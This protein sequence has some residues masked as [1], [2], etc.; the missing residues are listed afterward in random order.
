M[1]IWI[2][3]D[4]HFNHFNI[5]KYCNRPY[6]TIKEMNDALIKNWNDC[7]DDNDI[8][9][10]LG[11]FCFARPSEAFEVTKRL[12]SALKGY[13]VIVKGN[14]DFKKLKYTDIGWKFETFQELGIGRF[15]FRHRPDGP[16][17]LQS[18]AKMYDFVFYG[19]VHDKTLDW[20]PI[21][22][23]NVCLDANNFKPMDITDYFTDGEIGTIKRLVDYR[24]D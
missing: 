13:K 12:T 5:I 9:F 24:G 4:T 23:I 20:A 1:K 14:H 8:V 11:D 6:A 2:C 3:S 18:A 19:H 15:C 17:T 21:N 22:C 10:F 7:V 16:D